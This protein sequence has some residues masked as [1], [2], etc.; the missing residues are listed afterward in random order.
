MYVINYKLH[1]SCIWKRLQCGIAMPHQL[2]NAGFAKFCLGVFL[3]SVRK[4]CFSLNC[5]YI[6]NF[7]YLGLIKFNRNRINEVRAYLWCSC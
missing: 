1:T 3:V 7:T 6:L 2:S 5:F 4:C